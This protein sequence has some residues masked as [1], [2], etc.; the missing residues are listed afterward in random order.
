MSE[1]IT[2]G[3]EGILGDVSGGAYRRETGAFGLERW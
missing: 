1:N 3:R 2:A